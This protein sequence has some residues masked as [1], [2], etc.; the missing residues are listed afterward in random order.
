M[1]LITPDFGIIFWQ[2]ITFLVVLLVLSKFAWR[3]ILAILKAREDAVAHAVYK[4]TEAKVLTKQLEDDRTKLMEEAHLERERIIGEALVTQRAIIDQAHREALVVKER[5]LAEA[6]VAITREEERALETVKAN[7]GLL[8]VQI[9]EKLLVK[10][11]SQDP[12]QWALI[13]RLMANQL[14]NACK[15]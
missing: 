15:P 5:L 12:S 1:T 6:K 10:E 2:T 8:V 7:V 4:I 9:A 3:P 13:E 11:L 14:P